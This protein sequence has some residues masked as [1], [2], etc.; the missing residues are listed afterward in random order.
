MGFKVAYGRIEYTGGDWPTSTY[1]A[2]DLSIEKWDF[3]SEV[4]VLSGNPPSDGGTGTCALCKLHFGPIS[5]GACPVAQ[6][7]H[8]KCSGTPYEQYANSLSWPSTC[9]IAAGREAEYL[10]DLKGKWVAEK[11]MEIKPLMNLFSDSFTIG[12]ECV[13]KPSGLKMIKNKQL[14]WAAG[15]EYWRQIAFEGTLKWGRAGKDVSCPFCSSE[16]MTCV[17]AKPGIEKYPELEKAFKLWVRRPSQP[18]SSD[19]EAVYRGL[20]DAYLTTL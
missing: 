11:I 14:T 10:R 5:C 17:F 7:G 9:I 16:Y 15:L 3:I 19:A 2:L 13:M 12:D 4:I 1:R 20:M 8:T 6:D 18:R